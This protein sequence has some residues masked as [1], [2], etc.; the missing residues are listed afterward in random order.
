MRY[1]CGEGVVLD[2]VVREGFSE[3]VTLVLRLEGLEAVVV[4]E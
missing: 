1:G 4:E 2:A 3:E